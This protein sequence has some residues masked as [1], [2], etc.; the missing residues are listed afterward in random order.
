M[1]VLIK[2][3]YCLGKSSIQYF[4]PLK[5]Q[6]D[7][8]YEVEC[9]NGHKFTANILYH[10][11]QLL[12]EIGINAI[13]DGYFREALSSFTASYERF[14]ELFLKITAESNGA[15]IKDID[16]TWKLVSKQSERQLGAYIFIH[17][18]VFGQAP[19]ILSNNLTNLRNRV[20]HQGYIPTEMECIAFGNA[21]L[22]L[23]NTPIKLLYESEKHNFALMRSINDRGDFSPEGPNV[24]V[25]PYA[26]IGTNR[27]PNSDKNFSVESLVMSTKATRNRALPDNEK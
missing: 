21:I 2:C 8:V 24:T 4:I 1:K 10:Q 6:N 9:K 5:P 15:M 18:H 23:I 3:P 12:F 17:F 7:C 26:M 14:M 13:V 20:I 16:H 11:F 25:L 27:P 19:A 22:N